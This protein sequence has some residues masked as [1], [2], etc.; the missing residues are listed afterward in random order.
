MHDKGTGHN[1]DDIRKIAELEQQLEELKQYDVR[2]YTHHCDCSGYADEMEQR[3]KEL[4]QQLAEATDALVEVEC[5]VDSELASIIREA[6]RYIDLLRTQNAKLIESLK[7]IIKTKDLQ[8]ISYNKHDIMVDIAAAVLK[9]M[10]ANV[11]RDARIKELMEQTAT[12]NSLSLYNAFKQFENEIA[13]EQQS[14]LYLLAELILKTHAGD[15]WI[16]QY[17]DNPGVCVCE[18]CQLARELLEVE[19][20]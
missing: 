7:E 4:E 12:P 5:Y 3:N 17:S 20:C 14:K 2:T 9:E 8:S 18:A 16:T 19:K 10:E 1:A 15:D 6:V 13:Q 11:S